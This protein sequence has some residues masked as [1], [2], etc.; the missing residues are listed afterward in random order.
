MRK[1]YVAIIVTGV[2]VLLFGSTILGL[3]YNR[4]QNLC[5]S[6]T[7]SRVQTAHDAIDAIRNY[8][9]DLG[10]FS[11]VDRI[12]SK[13]R[14]T[15]AFRRDGYATFIRNDDGYRYR[16]GGGWRVEEWT[17]PMITRRYSVDF[18]YFDLEFQPVVEIK[19]DVLECGAIDIP[20]CL[21]FGGIY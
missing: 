7:K 4:V 17:K 11:L 20:N 14:Q 21:T 3:E 6:S 1:V 18:E 5:R 13:V 2:S 8:Q 9:V 12:L 19:C 15:D 16:K 10:K